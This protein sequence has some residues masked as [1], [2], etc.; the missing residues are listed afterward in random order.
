MILIEKDNASKAKIATDYGE[1]AIE[2]RALLANTKDK[3]KSFWRKITG[4]WN[5][6]ATRKAA[7]EAIDAGNNLLEKVE[8]TSKNEAEIIKK[9]KVVKQ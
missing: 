9:I 1:T 2:K 7:N 6:S 8:T 4:S 3:C 5:K